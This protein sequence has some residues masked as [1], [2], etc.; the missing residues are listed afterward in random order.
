MI[1]K[2]GSMGINLIKYYEGL[3]LKAYQDTGGVWT[4]GYG[5]TK[6]VK[7]GMV[8]TEERAEEL[9]REDLLEAEQAVYQLVPYGLAQHQFDALV[10]F[11]FNVGKNAFKKSTL[12]R[13]MLIGDILGASQQFGRWVYDNGKKLNGLI[14]RR[15]AERKLFLIG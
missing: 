6:G 5:H 1:R 4:I 7:K 10:S 12:L 3:R 14:E 13:L 8:I 11:V 15:E 2:T 9:L